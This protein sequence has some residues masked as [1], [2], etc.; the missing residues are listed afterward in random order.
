MI[1]NTNKEK[2]NAGLAMGIA[3]FGA[4]GYTV[5]I[6]LNDT[7]DYDFIIE[8]EGIFKTVQC[9]STGYVTSSGTYKLTLSSSGGTNGKKY[10]TVIETG[11]DLL[12]AL[13]GDG[14]MYVIPVKDIKNIKSI[15]LITEKNK[16]S[17]KDCI[18]TSKYI[19]TI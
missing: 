2:G 9:K 12:F 4:N 14:V 17:N 3:Y 6:P 16:Y 13:R 11:V 7:Q 10:K 18:D 15:N 19:V 8:K 5:S 1:F